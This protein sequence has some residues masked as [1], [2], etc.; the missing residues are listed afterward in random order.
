MTHSYFVGGTA[1]AYD[2]DTLCTGSLCQFNHLFVLRILNDHLGQRRLMSMNH[3]IY[4]IFVDTAK[5]S[6]GIHRHRSSE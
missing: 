1:N 3:D 5:V 2:V 4:I 6:L